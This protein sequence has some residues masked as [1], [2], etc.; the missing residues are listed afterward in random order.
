MNTRPALFESLETRRLMS[1]T[2]VDALAAEPQPEPAMLLPAVQKVRDAAARMPALDDGKGYV[3]TGV[4]H[5]ARSDGTSS[6]FLVS[7]QLPGSG[8]A[9]TD[10]TSNT[11][12]LAEKYVPGGGAIADGTSNTVLLAE[13]HQ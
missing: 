9:V 8:G 11:I 2:C 6:T 5:A 3:L 4:S 13:S 12:L 1:A 7:E 10:G